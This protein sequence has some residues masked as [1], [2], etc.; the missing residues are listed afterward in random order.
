MAD[1]FGGTDACGAWSWR[2][3]YDVMEAA[4]LRC[5]QRSSPE[6]DAATELQ[7]LLHLHQSLP[8]QT[9]R[10]EHQI[11]LQQFSTPLAYALVAAEAAHLTRKDLILEP[12]A[13]TGSLALFAQRASANLCLNEIDPFRAALLKANFKGDVTAHDAEHIDDLLDCDQRPAVIL[14]N[15][16]FA[17]SAKRTG[18]PTIAVRL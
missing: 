7:R 11:R 8:T 16:P 18:D 13:G 14:M 1:A 10:S 6:G 9:R 4:F 12:S 3:A 2:M 17:L 15:P 5:V